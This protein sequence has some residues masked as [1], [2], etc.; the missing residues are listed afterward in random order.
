MHCSAE[1]VLYVCVCVS[2]H[3]VVGMMFDLDLE[4]HHLFSLPLGEEG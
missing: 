2:V 4:Q 3:G 1:V